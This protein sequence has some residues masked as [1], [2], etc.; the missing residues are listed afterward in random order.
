MYELNVGDMTCMHCVATIKQAVLEVDAQA[1]VEVDLAAKTVRIVSV[2]T[3]D[4]LVCAIEDA[5]FP[6]LGKS[7]LV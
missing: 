6:V 4:A 1:K 5:G 2:E 7:A 3:L